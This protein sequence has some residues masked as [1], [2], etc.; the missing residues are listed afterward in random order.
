MATYRV[1]VREGLC[2]INSQP[3]LPV[4][5]CRREKAD[6]IEVQCATFHRIHV[7]GDGEGVVAAWGITLGHNLELMFCPLILDGFRRNLDRAENLIGQVGLQRCG[8][9]AVIGTLDPKRTGVLLLADS[10]SPVP[11]VLEADFA[12][13]VASGRNSQRCRQG[14]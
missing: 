5:I 4:F 10:D 12:C 7:E 14:L 3:I 8:E 2:N 1:Q 11:L 6:E 13:A 9:G